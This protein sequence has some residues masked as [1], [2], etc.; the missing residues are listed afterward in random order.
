M[1]SI[2]PSGNELSGSVTQWIEDVKSGQGDAAHKLWDRYFARLVSLANRKLHHVAKQEADEEDVAVQALNSF[3]G[4]AKKGQYPKLTDRDDL[5]ALLASIVENKAHK[6][7]RRQAA[8]KRGGGKVRIDLDLDKQV[9][10]ST[11]PTLD[12]LS[13]ELREQLNRLND[14]QLRQIVVLVL[15][16][17]TNAEIAVQLNVHVRTV[18][19]RRLLVRKKWQ[20]EL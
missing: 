13:L 19:R 9:Q 7:R 4:G 17:H 16:G 1:S 12:E 10:D 18:E 11:Y 5:W 8:L 6:V 20:A 15:H 14:E 3:F 2:E